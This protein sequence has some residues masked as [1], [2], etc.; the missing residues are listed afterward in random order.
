MERFAPYRHGRPK[1][2]VVDDQSLNIRVLHQLF[3]DECDVHMAT[4][5]EQAL[6]V[7]QELL[8]DLI[9]L[10]VMM[11][12]LDGYQ[13]CQRLK[14]IP[15]TRDIPVIFV[16]GKSDEDDEA[17]G[18]E[19]GAVDY[20]SKPFNPVVV[21]ARVRTHL[22]LKLQNDY[23]HALA[24]LDGL[25]GIPNRRAFDEHLAVAWAQACRDGRPLSLLM[26]DVDHFKKYNDHYGHL[27]GDQCLQQVAQ[28]LAS[29][30]HRPY[31]L[32][33]RFGGEEFAGL[34]PDT[35]ESG[36][37]QLAQRMQAAIAEL[38]LEHAAS[39]VSDRLTLSIG[40][41]TMRPT[42]LGSADQHLSYADEQLYRA[43]HEGRNRICAHFYDE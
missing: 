4:S 39:D 35:D 14:E 33:A 43:K 2:L 9:L 30:L 16:T 10:D 42:P 28:A 3:R 41:A 40:L 19:L 24:M 12:G 23:L 29:V 38:E 15:A 25:T 37:L 6:N 21:R 26:I 7:C 27:Q 18:F 20:I 8:P 22:T 36:A 13:V 17:K 5:G 32:L 31:D 1:L 34:L 11:E